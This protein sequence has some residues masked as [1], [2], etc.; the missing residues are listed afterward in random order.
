[1]YKDVKINEIKIYSK[2]PGT[3]GKEKEKYLCLK[4]IQQNLQEEN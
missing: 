3:F 2:V 1:M 4:L